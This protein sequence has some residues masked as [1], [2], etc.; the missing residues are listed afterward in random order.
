LTL[1]DEELFM[2][3]L[4]ITKERLILVPPADTHSNHMK[5]YDQIDI[6]LDTFPYS[7]TTTTCEALSM[8]KPVITLYHSGI[9]AHNVSSSILSNMGCF[10]LIAKSEHEYVSKAIEV[11]S[12]LQNYTDIRDK[13]I[14]SMNPKQFTK[15]FEEV[16]IMTHAMKLE[17]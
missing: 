16:L 9:H 4:G 7:G 8:N 3:V 12:S 17:S 15:E 2:K 14:S 11:A 1:E 10:D 5:V 6:C 13:F